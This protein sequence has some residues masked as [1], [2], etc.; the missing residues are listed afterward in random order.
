[1]ERRRRRLGLAIIMGKGE[2]EREI[3]EREKFSFPEM[4]NSMGVGRVGDLP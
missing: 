4:P 1:M 3:G 2:R